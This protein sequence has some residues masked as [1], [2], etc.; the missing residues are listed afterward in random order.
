MEELTI[1]YQTSACLV[2]DLRALLSKA[3]RTGNKPLEILARQLLESTVKIEQTLNELE[4][5][6]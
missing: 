4:T 2:S 5:S 1:A 3:I 6:K